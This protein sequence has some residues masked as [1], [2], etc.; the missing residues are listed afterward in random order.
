MSLVER[1][2]RWQKA[3]SQAQAS[4]RELVALGAVEWPYES[5][6]DHRPPG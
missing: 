2:E 6:H 1:Y 4:I 5:E 3:S